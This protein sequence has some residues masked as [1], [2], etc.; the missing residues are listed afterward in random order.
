M[1]IFEERPLEG[2]KGRAK[3]GKQDF[4]FY[5]KIKTKMLLFDFSSL[6]VIL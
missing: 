2:F 5:K 6:S 4:F 1:V 3:C